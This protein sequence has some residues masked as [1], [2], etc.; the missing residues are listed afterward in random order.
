MGY[1][2]LNFEFI[3]EKIGNFNIKVWF[4]ANVFYQCFLQILICWSFFSEFYTHNWHNNYINCNCL[5]HL[6]TFDLL[7][8]WNTWK[9]MDPAFIIKRKRQRIDTSSACFFC[10]NNAGD[11]RTSSAE[12]KAR[13]RAVDEQRRQLVDSSY[14]YVL[15]RL[16][17]SFQWRVWRFGIEMAQNMLF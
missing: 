17:I 13:T 16:N 12:G 2:V 15:E 14:V 1:Q 10:H 11:L 5:F 3:H 7:R 8:P 6:H 9:R 4:S